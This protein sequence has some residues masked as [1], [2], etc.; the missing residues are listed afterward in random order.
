VLADT[1]YPGWKATVDG[2]PTRVYRANCVFRAVRVPSGA[3]MVAWVFKPEAFRIGLWAGMVS[4]VVV[5]GLV[6]KIYPI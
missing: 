4:I 1:W 5:I 6:A 3:H 2:T